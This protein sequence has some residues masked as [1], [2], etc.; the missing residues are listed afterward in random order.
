MVH[1]RAGKSRLDLLAFQSPFSGSKLPAE[2]LFGEL[3]FLQCCRQGFGRALGCNWRK[4]ASK[5]F[6]NTVNCLFTPKVK[7]D[8]QRYY[9][10]KY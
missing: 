4:L 1:V 7:S 6:E 2:N 5:S 9:F 8:R 10:T 3:E